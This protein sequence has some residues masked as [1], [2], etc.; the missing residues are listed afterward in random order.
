M[1]TFRL[2]LS[3]A[4][5]CLA[6]YLFVSAPAPLP[7]V[8]IDAVQSRHVETE[9]M[10]NATN[11]INEAARHIYTSRIVG[12]GLKRGLSFGEDWAEPNVEKGPLPA[13][14]LRLVAQEL[15]TRPTRLSLYLG[16]D[17]P[18]NKSNLF[19]DS[20]AATFEILKT[21]EDAVFS[22]IPD[23][24]T[25]GMYPDVATVAA[26]VTCHNEHKDSPKKDWELNDIMGATTWIYPS[27]ALGA[28]DYL[29]ATEQVFESVASAYQRYL[30]KNATFETPIF[31]GNGWPDEEILML[32]SVETFMKEVRRVASV[33]IVDELILTSSA[34]AP[35]EPR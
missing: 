30:D 28:G 35:E 12:A 24:G 10:F 9:K 33:K 34:N 3:G 31:I 11:A 13:L 20:Q 26:C 16:S 5:F 4:I 23:T 21:T 6:T 32:P 19:D 22:N 29:N 1:S 25:V 2:A 7:D 15:E 18:I 8:P 27:E 17:A 14:F